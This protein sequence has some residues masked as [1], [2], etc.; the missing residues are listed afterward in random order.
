[1]FIER[2]NEFYGINVWIDVVEKKIREVEDIII[3]NI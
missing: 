1:M 2:K 3:E